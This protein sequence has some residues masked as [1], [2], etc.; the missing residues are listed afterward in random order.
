MSVDE[1]PRVVATAC[2]AAQV[3]KNLFPRQSLGQLCATRL[4]ASAGPALSLIY[5]RSSL[6]AAGLRPWVA[7]S[8]R[9]Y[10]LT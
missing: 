9:A 6:T 7:L 10:A 1:C 8:H 3:A 2:A 4:R 5:A